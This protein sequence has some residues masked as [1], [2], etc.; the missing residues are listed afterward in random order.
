MSWA[1]KETKNQ[2]NYINTFIENVGDKC[3]SEYTKA[4]AVA[5]KTWL[6]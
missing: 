4:D 6:L 2:Q 5:F 3:L 1:P